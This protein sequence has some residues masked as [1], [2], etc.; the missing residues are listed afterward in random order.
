MGEN[1]L[2]TPSTI[3]SYSR[4]PVTSQLLSGTTALLFNNYV[5]YLAFNTLDDMH[6]GETA[7][8]LIKSKLYT[9]YIHLYNIL[10]KRTEFGKFRIHLKVHSP[11]TFI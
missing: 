2:H 11:T 4:V 8:R 6:V 1:K 10:F 5:H 3:Y 7:Q 9:K